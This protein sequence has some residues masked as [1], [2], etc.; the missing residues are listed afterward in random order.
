[1]FR[2][3]GDER[4]FKALRGAIGAAYRPCDLPN[5]K[6]HVPFNGDEMLTTFIAQFGKAC[7]LPEGAREPPTSPFKYH[8]RVS[9][10][11]RNV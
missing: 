6:V 1:M 5:G 3:V 10:P 2:K 8:A 11:R 9:M 7:G 4:V